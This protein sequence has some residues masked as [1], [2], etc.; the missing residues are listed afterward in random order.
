MI[1]KMEAV[2][3]QGSVL[4]FSFTDYLN[5][6]IIE[7]IEGLGPTKATITSSSVAGKDGAQYQS[8]RREARNIVI[9][10]ILEPDYV[11]NSVSDL[12]S[13]L[14]SYF[15]TNR[16]VTLKFYDEE[17]SSV[18]IEGIVESADPDIFT[19]DPNMVVSIMCM[20]PDYFGSSVTF[21]GTTVSTN[22]DTTVQYNGTVD[23][24]ILLTLEPNRSL[25]EFTV[26]QR[27]SD[28]SLRSLN[29]SAPLLTGDKLS[30]NTVRGSKGATLLRANISSSV[31]WGISPQ[32]SWISLEPGVNLIRVYA[33][34]AAVPYKIEYTTR[35]GGL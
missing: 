26:Y 3:S 2:S 1:V 7:K 10:F 18:F 8:S 12:R 30:I 31:L 5:G 24:G 21:D 9:T 14:Y 32:S 28:G 17:G 19:S 34:G 11:T 15:M 16:K 33:E 25:N 20:D 22:T 35:Y 27:I 13:T 6:F 23:T 29:F 4:A